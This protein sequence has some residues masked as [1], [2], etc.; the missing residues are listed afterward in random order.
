[1][2]AQFIKAIKIGNDFKEIKCLINVDWIATVCDDSVFGCRLL[3]K[4]GEQAEVRIEYADLIDILEIL[5]D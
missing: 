1:M 4:C 5:N 2:T 3:L